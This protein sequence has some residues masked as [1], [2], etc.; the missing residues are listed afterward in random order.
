MAK[1]TTFVGGV[2]YQNYKAGYD[3]EHCGNSVSWESSCR[4]SYG[5]SVTHNSYRSSVSLNPFA[6]KDLLKIQARQNLEQKRLELLANWR[7]GVISRPNR[8]NQV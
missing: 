5:Q 1:T 8:Y 7:K 3:C 6:N 4:S 2:A